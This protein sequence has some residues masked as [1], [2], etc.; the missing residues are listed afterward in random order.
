MRISRLAL[1]AAIVAACACKGRFALP[2]DAR[3]VSEIALGDGFGCARMKDGSVRCWGANEAGQLGDGTREARA[4][5]VRASVVAGKAS[6]LA[7]G[8][9]EAC[10]VATGSGTGTVCWGSAGALAI[11]GE[12]AKQIAVGAGHACALSAAGDVTCAAASGAAQ[13]TFVR[14]ATFLAAGGDTTCAILRDRS[15]TCWRRAPGG[16]FG[17]PSRVEGLADVTD[18]AIGATHSCAVRAWGGVA[19]WGEGTDGELGDGAFEDRALPVDVAGLAVPARAVAVGR[20]HT[21]VLLRDGTVHCWGANENAQLSDG[22]TN[23][24]A[25]HELVNGVFEVEQITAAGDATCARLSDGSARCWGGLALPKTP[26][27]RMAVPTEVRW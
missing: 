12:G 10:A 1:L 6:V 17:A 16:G 18:V 4:E 3:F 11:P 13:E 14:G 20:A 26:G 21:C 27:T 24:R 25:T 22:T 5:S 8:G 15:V 19:C 23:R 9:K 7:V 2:A